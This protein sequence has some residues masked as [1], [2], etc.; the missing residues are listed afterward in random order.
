MPFRSKFETFNRGRNKKGK[1][2][3]KKN[4]NIANILNEPVD[5]KRRL[6][7]KLRLRETSIKN[8]EIIKILVS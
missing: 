4:I 1:G 3:I 7:E 2:Q 5:L 8:E 6:Y